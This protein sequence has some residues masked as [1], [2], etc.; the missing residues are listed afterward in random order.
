MTYGVTVLARARKDIQ[1]IHD[2]LAERSPSGAERW[3]DHFEEATEILRRNPFVA[4]IAPESKHFEVEIRHMIFRT[5][6]GRPYRA[7]FIVIEDDVRIL[8]VRGPGQPDLR[9]IDITWE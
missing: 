3:L 9:S 1:S 6:S 4:P 5:P 7:I 2:W 8:R